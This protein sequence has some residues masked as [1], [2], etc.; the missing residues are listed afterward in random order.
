MPDAKV[1]TLS[2]LSG[3]D[4]AAADVLYVADV[5][6]GQSK[7]IRADALTLGPQVVLPTGRINASATGDGSFTQWTYAPFQVA[8]AAFNSRFAESDNPSANPRKNVVMYWGYNTARVAGEHSFF[9]VLE[10]CYG[11]AGEEQVE[12]YWEAFALDGTSIRPVSCVFNRAT[13]AGTLVNFVASS[14]QFTS[15]TSETAAVTLNATGPLHF[16]SGNGGGN[17]GAL[18]YTLYTAA[19]VLYFQGDADYGLR[20]DLRGTSS[21]PGIAVWAATGQSHYLFQGQVNAVTLFQVSADGSINTGTVN[22]ATLADKQQVSELMTIGTGATTDSSANLLPADADI[23]GVAYRVTV[24]PP[25]TSSF[26]LGDASADDKF[27]DAGT[28]STA[29]VVGSSLTKAVAQ[30]QFAQAAAAKIRFTP[31]TPPSDNTGRVRVTVWYRTITP[32][33]S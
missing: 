17:N 30:G 14:V 10:S 12:R 22:G 27:A 24:Q 26:K 15:Q 20:W 21:L 13:G 31:N 6:A 4:L 18:A 11:P 33:T 16:G 25:G 7:S 3:E 1:S 2:A 32:P 8:S 19:G 9:D 23:L 29:N 28:S 5:S